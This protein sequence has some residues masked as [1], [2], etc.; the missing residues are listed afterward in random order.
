MRVGGKG[1]S[2]KFLN[3]YQIATMIGNYKKLTHGK[4]VIRDI[5]ECFIV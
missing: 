5:T 2:M 4:E 1:N 3:T